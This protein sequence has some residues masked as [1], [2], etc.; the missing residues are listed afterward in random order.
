MRI[1]SNNFNFFTFKIFAILTSMII[2][3][4]VFIFFKNLE[5]MKI[6]AK[7]K[8][9]YQ[10]YILILIIFNSAQNIFSY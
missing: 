4:L 1:K 6:N 5:N 10:Y 9:N 8:K 3:Y 7:L 2:N